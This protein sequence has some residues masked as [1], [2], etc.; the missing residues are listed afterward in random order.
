M[1]VIYMFI[2]TSI[3]L[4]IIIIIIIIVV[5]VVIIIILFYYKFINLILFNMPFIQIFIITSI[6]FLIIIIIIIILFASTQKQFLIVTFGT[7]CKHNISYDD[8]LQQ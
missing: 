3:H 5:F 2:I 1:S 4:L 8:L 7:E 6:H